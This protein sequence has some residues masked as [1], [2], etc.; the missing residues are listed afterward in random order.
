[1]SYQFQQSEAARKARA[2]IAQAEEAQ[3]RAQEKLA[4]TL[5]VEAELTTR[6]EAA[7]REARRIER[8]I[9]RRTAKKTKRAA[10]LEAQLAAHIATTAAE[11]SARLEAPTYLPTPEAREYWQRYKAT[12][13]DTELPEVGWRRLQAATREAMAHDARKRNAA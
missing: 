7:E 13:P 1:M 3:C 10:D 2:V 8:R 4:E 11:L 5:R 12:H 6:R 9:E